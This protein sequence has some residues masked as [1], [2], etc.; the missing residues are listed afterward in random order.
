MCFNATV[1]L[2]T[3]YFGLICAFITLLLGQ[4]SLIKI[5]TVLSITSMQLLEYF[6]WTNINDKEKIRQLSVIGLYIIAIQ[7]TL[8]NY[9]I[10]NDKYRNI[11]L[12]L[13]LTFII[14]YS[15]FGIK[16]TRF[17]MEKGENGHLIWYW[18]N[19]NIFWIISVFLLYLIPTYLNNKLIFIFAL[20]SLLISLYYYYKYKTW[21]TIWCY[22]S[23]FVWIFIIIYSIFKI[24][25]WN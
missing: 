1:S 4:M 15:I 13:L 5:L 18:A 22:I 23:N 10:S 21:G 6:A 24:Y 19:V 2:Q 3:F 25:G 8:I 20:L 14:I 7:L 16:Y 12:T 9:G 11:L 17:H